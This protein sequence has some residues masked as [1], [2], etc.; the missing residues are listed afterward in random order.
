MLNKQVSLPH[1]WVICVTLVLTFTQDWL[2]DN[3]LDTLTTFFLVP[4]PVSAFGAVF[5]LFPA[6]SLE[7]DHF[8][9][10]TSS[11][12]PSASPLL[13]VSSKAAGVPFL[14]A[15]PPTVAPDTCVFVPFLVFLRIAFV[16]A[17]GG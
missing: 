17:C 11:P 7:F 3:H 13:L 2:R 12:F 6:E 10:V 14:S 8:S 5:D 1:F 4:A 15:V 16:L 9:G